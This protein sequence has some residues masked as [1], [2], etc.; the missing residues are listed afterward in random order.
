MWYM[1]VYVCI[2]VG[3]CICADMHALM[4]VEALG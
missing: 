1:R 2:S 4:C 3:T